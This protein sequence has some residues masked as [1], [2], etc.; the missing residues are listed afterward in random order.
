MGNRRFPEGS[1]S[2]PMDRMNS[3]TLR[4]LDVYMRLSSRADQVMDEMDQHTMP[5]VIR[6]ELAEE[7]SLVIA[8]SAITQ[9][10]PS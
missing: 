2:A 6:T 3:A 5:G 9:D 1:V 10:R 8:I 7:D 4:A